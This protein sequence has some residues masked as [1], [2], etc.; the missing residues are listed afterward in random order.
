MKRGVLI[1]MMG[2]TVLPAVAMAN[3]HSYV[4]VQFSQVEY[5]ESGVPD[6]EPTA[7]AI[8]AGAQLSDY[9]AVEARVGFGA[10]DDSASEGPAKLTIEVDNYISAY[11]KPTMPL[12][13]RFSVY[14][15][16]GV[17]RSKIK[18]EIT[19]VVPATSDTDS[20]TDLSY[21]VGADLNLST[22]SFVSVE[23]ARLLNGDDYDL[24]ALS[25][26]LG[27]RF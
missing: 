6:V 11:I 12:G 17:T 25:V 10:G 19:G 14:A 16:A 1:L 24:D 22:N 3:Q 13:E 23:Y 18:G 9:L 21:G 15:L 4:G 5:K 27:F 8:K 26:G 2:A 20:Q 7:I